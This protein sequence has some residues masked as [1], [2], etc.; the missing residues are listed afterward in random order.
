MT[1]D[2][3][4]KL[5]WRGSGSSLKWEVGSGSAVKRKEGSGSAT[6]LKLTEDIL[7]T[8]NLE[9]A[10]DETLAVEV[11]Q[12]EAKEANLHLHIRLCNILPLPGRQNLQGNNI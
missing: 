7:V 12:V 8:T 9:W 2:H 4:L 6:R 5:L 3:L 11:E 10:G 1:S